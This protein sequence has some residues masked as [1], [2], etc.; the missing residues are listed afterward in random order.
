MA[1]RG[2]LLWLQKKKK[3]ND[4]DSY[5]IYDLSEQFPNEF[6]VSMAFITARCPFVNYGPI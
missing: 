3:E 4:A 6:M 5:S 1:S 2:R